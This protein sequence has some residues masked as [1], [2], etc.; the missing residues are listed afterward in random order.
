MLWRSSGSALF[1]KTYAVSAVQLP[2]RRRTLINSAY[3]FLITGRDVLLFEK[4]I[5]V[6]SSGQS[7]FRKCVRTGAWSDTCR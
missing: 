4:R 6:V 3:E 5:N 1:E 2:E 7:I